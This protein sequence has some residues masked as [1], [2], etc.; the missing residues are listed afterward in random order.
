MLVL[1]EAFKM[2]VHQPIMMILVF[3]GSLIGLVFGAI[4]GL[5]ATTGVALALPLTFALNPEMGMALLIGIYVGG[6]SGGFIAAALLGIP[7]TPASIATCFDAYPLSQQ[8]QPVKALGIGVIASFIGTLGSIICLIY[9]APVVANIALKLSPF[10]YTSLMFCALTLIAT[11]ARE[12][13]FRGLA[14]GFLGI[15][16]GTI[17]IAPIGSTLRFTFGMVPLSAGIN[18]LAL[19]LG[20]F[21]IKQI[22]VDHA[23]D[24]PIPQVDLKVTGL[25]IGIGEIV[26]N[27]WNIIRSFF[28]G[29]WIGFL[30]GMGAGVANLIAYAQ[31]KSA[32]KHPEKFGKGATEGI[33]ASEVSNNAAIGGAMIPMLSLGIPG[34]SVTALLLGGLMI[35]GLIPGPLLYIKQPKL[36]NSIFGIL[37]IAAVICLVICYLGMRLFP[38]VLTI[39]RYYLYPVL[40][41]LSYVGAFASNNYS[42]DF[43]IMLLFALVGLVMDITKMPMSPMILGFILGPMVEENLRR[44]LTYSAGSWLPFITRPVSAV[45]LSIA[46]FS[47]IS[48]IIKMRRNR[49]LQDNQSALA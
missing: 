2:V 5:T 43:W 31:A 28:I 27:A 45:L 32:S 6:I 16:L 3:V 4:P 14:S 19:I 15:L 49:V 48:S 9:I 47:I 42:F 1:A 25:G 37:A 12:E 8:G 39:P 22:C 40:M 17:G 44:A 46:V 11:L 41:V 26:D 35:H 13:P 34:D 7:G 10:E 33:W 21:A 29:L 36:V 30:P 23:E 20:V 24:K 18:L 38:R